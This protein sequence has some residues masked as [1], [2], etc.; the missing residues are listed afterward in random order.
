MPWT[1]T[2]RWPASSTTDPVLHTGRSRSVLCGLV[3]VLLVGVAGC[4]AQNHDESLLGPASPS[5]GAAVASASPRASTTPDDRPRTRGA[6]L[7]AYADAVLDRDRQRFAALLGG[8]GDF[9][10]QQLRLYDNLQ[11][12]P[13]RGLRLSVDGSQVTRTLRLGSYDD[14]AATSPAGFAVVVRSG[15]AVAVPDQAHRATAPWDL[16][17]IRA[18]VDGGALVV[19]DVADSDQLP[20]LLEAAHAAI[21]DDDKVIELSWSHTVVVYAFRDRA[22]TASYSQVPG[23]NPRHLGALTYPIRDGSG[24]ETGSRVAVLPAAL[25]VGD[26]ELRRVLRHE[27]TH[28]AVGALDDDVPTW[29]GEGL[30]EYVAA[31]PTPRRERRIATVALEQARGHAIAIPADFTSGDQTLHYAESWQA[32]EYLA[33]AKGAGVLWDLL[34][35]MHRAAIGRDGGQGVGQDA[36]LRQVAGLDTSRLALRTGALIRR[37]YG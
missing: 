11:R 20:R 34:Q 25:E 32:C 1:A 24:E 29:L 16:T 36:V 2:T 19:T 10:E 4:G 7:T 23:G 13:V 6:L 18:G 26:A 17:E 35:A 9:R 15:H 3:L 14:R 21:V 28:V 8:D 30:A 33:S 12:L 5:A 22:V 37:V 27:V 31:A